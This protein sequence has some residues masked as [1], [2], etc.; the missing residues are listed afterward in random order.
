MFARACALGSGLAA[1][2]FVWMCAIGRA[3]LLQ[4]HILDGVLRRAGAQPA[5]RPLGRAARQA[6]LRGVRHRQQD[7]HLLRAVAFDP[8]HARRAVHPSL[9]RAAHA[10]LAP[11]RVRGVHGRDEPVARGASASWRG[12]TSRPRASSGSASR[13]SCSSSARARSCCSSPAA[14]S[15]TTRPSCGARRGRSPRSP[16]FSSCDS[17]RRVRAVAWSGAFTALALL[18]RRLGRARSRRRA[19]LG[20]RRPTARAR[21]P[22]AHDR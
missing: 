11:A 16:R 10:T 3:T 15:C 22:P 4:S 20:A 19:R 12:A 21:A 2:P 13:C 8:A 18:T 5:R 6:R 9:R 14:R 7:L 1:I 17:D